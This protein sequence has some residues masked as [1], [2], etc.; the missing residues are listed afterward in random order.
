LAIKLIFSCIMPIR[1]T[2]QI[3]MESK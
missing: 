3:P 2:P 1:L